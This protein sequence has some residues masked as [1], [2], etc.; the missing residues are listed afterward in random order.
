V[1][2]IHGVV[3]EHSCIYL[4]SETSYEAH[5]SD[6]ANQRIGKFTGTAWHVIQATRRLC[7]YGLSLSALDAE[8]SWIVRVGLEAH[9]G[10]TLRIHLFDLRAELP[11]LEWRVRLLLPR[12]SDIQIEGHPVDEEAVAT[13]FRQESVNA[14]L[15]GFPT[16]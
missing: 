14:G 16:R 2:H 5:R 12:N 8:L 9:T 15:I 6:E 13:G 1:V 11:K 4:P 7:I 3:D 10:K